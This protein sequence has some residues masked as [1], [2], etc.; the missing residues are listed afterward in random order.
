MNKLS[1]DL[2]E[3]QRRDEKGNITIESSETD[4]KS[5]NEKS[6]IVYTGFVA[7]EVEQAA[8]EIGFD[9]SGVDAPKN[10]NDFYGLRYA[11]FVVPLVKAVQ[12]QQK[13]I[14]ELTRRIEQLER[15]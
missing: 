3:N 14:E 4:I 8:K 6:Q 1:A 11:E 12:E 5:R 9:F 13:I 15:K 2:K 7:Q 10:A